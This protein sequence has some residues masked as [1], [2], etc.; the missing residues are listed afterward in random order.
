MRAELIYN[1]VAG[2]IVIR[3]ILEDLIQFLNRSGWSV[4]IRQTTGPGEATELARDAALNG[5]QVVIAAGGDGTVSEVANGLIGSEAA[6]GVLPIGTSNTFALQMGIPTLNPLLPTKN[7]AKLLMDL[8]ENVA[9]PLP[10]NFYRKV[11]FN[12]ARVLVEKRTIRVDLGKLGDRYFLMWAGIGLDALITENVSLEE[13]QAY[14]AWAYIPRTIRTIR[15]FPGA[16]VRL[17]LDGKN[18][19]S[20]TTLII[21]SN[22]QLYAGI[23][24]VGLI[25]RVDDA[26]LDVCIFKGGGFFTFVQHALKV[27]SHRQLKDPQIDYHQCQKITIESV[28]D[29]PIHLDGEP[30]THTPVTIETVPSAIEVIVPK[31]YSG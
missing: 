6:L 15:Q 17:A 8:E 23:L 18:I 22:I 12:A 1:P 24:P 14:G 3:H 31:R 25:A 5:A 29:L 11:L 21:V 16:E 9:R 26:K 13:K 20:N 27:A 10:T 4:S 30:Y 28:R 19:V 2:Q 7:F